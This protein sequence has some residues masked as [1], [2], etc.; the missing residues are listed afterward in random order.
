MQQLLLPRDLHWSL[1]PI[2][3][4]NGPSELS[5]CA[6]DVL[7]GHR[8]F[9]S[10]SFQPPNI[11]HHVAHRCSVLLHRT[12]AGTFVD[13]L[14]N[15]ASAVMLLDVTQAFLAFLDYFKPAALTTSGPFTRFLIDSSSLRSNR[16]GMGMAG[17]V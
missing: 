1:A 5:R 8:I 12:G 2:Q 15:H 14:R 4:K 9:A 7:L 3:R 11:F 16:S 6:D 17:V 13:S 10:N